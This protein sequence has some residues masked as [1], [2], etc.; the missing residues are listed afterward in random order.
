[1]G[2]LRAAAT[3]AASVASRRLS[4]SGARSKGAG[5]FGGT[6]DTLLARLQQLVER[7]LRDG[8]P[9]TEDG[10]DDLLQLTNRLSVAEARLLLD[11]LEELVISQDAPPLLRA[12][13]ASGDE[14]AFQRV[15]VDNGRWAQK[16]EEV[17][18]TPDPEARAATQ[19]QQARRADAALELQRQT[20]RVDAER[21]RFRIAHRARCEMA[22]AAHGPRLRATLPG[23]AW[24]RPEGTPPPVWRS[25]SW[26]HLV[27]DDLRHALA[28][29]ARSASSA[30]RARADE[31]EDDMWRAYL[32]T[33][34]GGARATLPAVAADE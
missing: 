19:R 14:A 4:N 2:G 27:D 28:H 33:H 9:L 17:I 6:S 22:Y 21:S 29:V 8:Q 31:F 16:L 18:A 25:V 15:F 11:A 12:I 3:S 1:M 24:D 30:T 5:A 26:T 10:W 34:N 13:V 23:V 7:C 20:S 32:T